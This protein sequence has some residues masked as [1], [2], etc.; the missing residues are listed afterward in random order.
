M[1]SVAVPEDFIGIVGVSMLT[2]SILRGRNYSNILFVTMWSIYALCCLQPQG[3]ETNAAGQRLPRKGEVELLCGGPPC[4]GFSLLNRFRNSQNSR[5]KV[6]F[7]GPILEL[8]LKAL[9][10]SI[11]VNTNPGTC[12]ACL[13]YVLQSTSVKW[14]WNALR[15]V[16]VLRAHVYA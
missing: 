4:Q 2:R 9:K 6:S 13:K 1:G 14:L 10:Y 16:A 5:L 7:M 15:R 12:K 8:L 11:V 3:K